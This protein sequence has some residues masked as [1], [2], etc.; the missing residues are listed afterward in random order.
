MITMGNI[1]KLRPSADMSPDKTRKHGEMLQVALSLDNK[2]KTQIEFKNPGAI[3]N[4]AGE[5]PAG[6]LGAI[7]INS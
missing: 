1:E 5:P 7:M 3:K 4:G 2:H 6:P